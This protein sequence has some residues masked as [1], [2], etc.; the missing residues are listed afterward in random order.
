MRTEQL[1]SMQVSQLPR[2]Q[3]KEQ[4]QYSDCFLFAGQVLN[5]MAKCT[6]T[7]YQEDYQIY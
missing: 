4:K 7:M 3:I 1:N 5:A 6:Q 2:T